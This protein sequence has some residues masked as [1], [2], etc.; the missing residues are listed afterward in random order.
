MLFD[1]PMPDFRDDRH[2]EHLIW[3]GI[4]VLE[5]QAERPD[6]AAIIAAASRV[7]GVDPSRIVLLARG[8]GGRLETGP[9]RAAVLLYPGCDAAV[10]APHT[11]EILLVHGS[12]DAANPPAACSHAAEAWRAAR[13]RVRHDVVEGADYAFDYRPLGPDFRLS[14]PRPDGAGRITA[15]PWPEAT[16][17]LAQEAA[18]FLADALGVA[19]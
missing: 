12:A 2:V 1:G 3:S 9:V 6:I 5:P 4:A 19:P 13:L 18:R 16:E 17:F 14:L 15:M 8:A 7:V 10:S 11:G